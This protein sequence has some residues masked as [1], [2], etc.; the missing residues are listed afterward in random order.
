MCVLKPCTPHL[1][2]VAPLRARKADGGVVRLRTT[3]AFF[4]AHKQ[5]SGVLQH[6]LFCLQAIHWHGWICMN[7][8][9]ARP[10]GLRHLPAG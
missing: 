3:A 10:A 4:L 2:F 6:C 1:A 8:Q 5:A 7:K 9:R